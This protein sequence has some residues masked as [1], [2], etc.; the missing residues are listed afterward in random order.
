MVIR[1]T[2]KVLDQLPPDTPLAE[3]PAD[4]GDW[5]LNLL[6][7]ERRKCLLLVHAGTLFSVFRP[8][9]RKADLRDLPG[10]VAAMI[11]PELAREGLPHHTYGPLPP[12]AVVI[13]KTASRHTLGHVNEIAFHLQHVIARDGGLEHTDLDEVHH[14]LHRDLHNRHGTYIRPI[15]LAGS[16][17]GA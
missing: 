16:S 14:H 2:R 3:P 6:W 7:I 1:C 17:C 15:D 8:A 13:A 11:S 5:Y 12:P 10:L 4:D 9:I